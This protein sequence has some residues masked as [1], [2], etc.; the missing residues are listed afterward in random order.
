MPQ[1]PKHELKPLDLGNETIGQRIAGLRKERG[2]SQADLAEHIGISRQLVASYERGR[3]RLYDEMVAR[4]AL[5][6]GASADEILGIDPTHS[7]EAKTH[8]SLRLTRRLRE[9]ESLPEPKKKK[10]LNTLDDLI[11]ANS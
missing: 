6:L 7:A 5:A 4:F 1:V 2:L 9:L 3:V 10:I 8:P 11:R